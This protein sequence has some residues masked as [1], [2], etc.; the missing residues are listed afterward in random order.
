MNTPPAFPD[1]HFATIPV[2]ADRPSITA[3]DV[4]AMLVSAFIM[5]AAI[6]TEFA[7]TSL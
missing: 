7:P 3:W 6:A 4:L 5:L 1:D 2:R